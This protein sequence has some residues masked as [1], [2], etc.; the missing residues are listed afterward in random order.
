MQRRT[1]GPTLLARRAAPRPVT[2]RRADW[3]DAAAHLAWRLVN[4]RS[5]EPFLAPVAPTDLPR[6]H[7]TA[8]DGW[9]APLPY[10]PAPAG[11]HGEPVLLAHALGG[12]WRDFALEPV[13]ALA[14][15]LRDAGHAVYLLTHRG[16]RDARA[17]VAA[18]PFDLDDIATRDLP[19]ALD[20]VA[21]HSGFPR[22]AMVGH[23]LGG[24]LAYLSLALG[25][26]GRIAAL[27]TLCSA[28]RFTAPT[29]AA[30][31]ARLVATLLPRRW[32]LPTHAAARLALPFATPAALLD[33]PRTTAP[34]ARARLR[35]ASGDLHAGVLVQLSRA[36]AEGHLCDRT[37]R[38]DVVAALR[39]LPALVLAAADD[40]RCAPAQAWPAAER[41]GAARAVVP[42]G[43]LDPLTAREVREEV[44]QRLGAFLGAHR[45]ACWVPAA[46]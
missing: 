21:E 5:R 45:A 20:A 3:R 39:P 38:M 13:G 18:Q 12:S 8:D 9:V 32:V 35:Y 44:V 33:A 42:G 15:R 17:P 46:G 24:Q 14:R 27:A 6:I 11:T 25:C 10:L 30:R 31:H 29:S 2:R 4:A 23:A 16:D 26:G 37:G 41:L 36:V 19:A 1:P 34:V 40:A 43:H 7:Y 28:V 22:V